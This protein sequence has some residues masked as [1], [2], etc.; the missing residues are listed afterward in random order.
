MTRN[1]VSWVLCVFA[2]ACLVVWSISTAQAA[3]PQTDRGKYLVNVIGC[4]EC[5]TPGS[6]Y[7]HPDMRKF[8]AGSDFGYAVPGLGVF[9]GRNLTPDKKTGLGNWTAQ[10]IATAITTGVR[11][12]G[13]ILAIAMPWPDFANLTKADALAIAAY[14]RTLPPVRN[15]VPGPFGATEK[16]AV[17][18]VPLAPIAPNTY[19]KL[20]APPVPK[21]N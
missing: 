8:L 9:V 17:P 7:G 12:D 3:N 2:G 4:T 20:A 11:P 19:L 1:F 21:P 16:P 5:H 18:V 14:L 6:A 10:Q 15:I 13:R